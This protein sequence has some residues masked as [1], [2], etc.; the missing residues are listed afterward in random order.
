MGSTTYD[1]SPVFQAVQGLGQRMQYQKAL[2]AMMGGQNPQQTPQQP[3]QAALPTPA[4][5]VNPGSVGG[6]Q[7]PTQHIPSQP[8]PAPAPQMATPQAASN[9]Y[10]SM[11]PMLKFMDPSMG[12]PLL[13]QM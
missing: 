6:V 10:A 3:P 12:M 8:A 7:L 4:M 5:T 11:L 1:W 2:E 13:M 9:P